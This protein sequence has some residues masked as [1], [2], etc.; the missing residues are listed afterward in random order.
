MG[1]MGV[2]NNPS[3]WG[4]GWVRSYSVVSGKLSGMGASL[5]WTS[6]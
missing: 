4:T 5:G 6:R 2:A 3:D 1:T